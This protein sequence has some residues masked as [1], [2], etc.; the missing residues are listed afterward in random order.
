MKGSLLV[1]R[2]EHSFY[3]GSRERSLNSHEKARI[4]KILLLKGASSPAEKG[5]VSEKK[6]EGGKDIEKTPGRES[7]LPIHDWQTQRKSFQG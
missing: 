6:R 4:A 7:K 3:A 2:G 5:G 1:T